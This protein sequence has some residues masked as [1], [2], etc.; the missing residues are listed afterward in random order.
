MPTSSRRS[1]PLWAL[2]SIAWLGPGVIAAIQAYL[3]GWTDE[4]RARLRSLQIEAMTSE[5]YREGTRAFLEKRRPKFQ[6][7]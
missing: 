5:D 6:G 7:R 1:L 2:V 3:A 4:N